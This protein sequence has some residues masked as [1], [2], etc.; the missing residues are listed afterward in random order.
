M[1]CIGHS[2]VY[3]TFVPSVGSW[4]SRVAGSSRDS[5]NQIAVCLCVHNRINIMKSTHVLVCTSSRCAFLPSNMYLLSMYVYIT[6]HVLHWVHVYSSNVR[7]PSMYGYTEYVCILLEYVCIYRVCMVYRVCAYLL[8][9]YLFTGVVSIYSSS[10][11]VYN[12]V[13][14]HIPS[15]YVLANRMCMITQPCWLQYHQ[16]HTYPGG[17]LHTIAVKLNVYR[18]WTDQNDHQQPRQP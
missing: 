3:K 5:D 1:L 8:S 6:G 18:P 10:M 14:M 4:F 15:M 11:Y 2:Y 17:S 7:I 9:M 16:S 13:C 12:W